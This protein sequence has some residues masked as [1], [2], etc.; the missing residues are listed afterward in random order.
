MC[1]VYQSVITD[2]FFS[3]G[4]TQIV[5]RKSLLSGCGFKFYVVFLPAKLKTLPKCDPCLRTKSS[6]LKDSSIKLLIKLL[7]S[8]FINA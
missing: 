1:L 2:I 6:D 7:L 8:K 3:P 4:A 5:E